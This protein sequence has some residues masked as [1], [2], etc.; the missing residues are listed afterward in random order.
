MKPTN[1]Y[2]RLIVDHISPECACTNCGVWRKLGAA[3]D[4]TPAEPKP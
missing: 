4:S 1:E 2:D 3:L